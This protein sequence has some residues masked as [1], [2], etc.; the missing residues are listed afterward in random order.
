[1]RHQQHADTAINHLIAAR[2]AAHRAGD[3]RAADAYTT[4]IQKISRITDTVSPAA[5]LT[6]ELHGHPAVTDM[7][8]RAPGARTIELCDGSIISVGVS[9]GHGH[10]YAIDGRRLDWVASGPA[11]GN[12]LVAEHTSYDD[13]TF[14]QFIQTA[15]ENALT[16]A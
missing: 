10:D 5:Y 16:A 11:A 12:Q 7:V 15:A 13:R 1:M 3:Q 6:A 8:T 2:T 9:D 4:A 14:R